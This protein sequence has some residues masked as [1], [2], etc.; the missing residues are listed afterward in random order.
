MDFSNQYR[1]QKDLSDLFAGL[2][3]DEPS[4]PFSKHSW[5]E[6]NT[7]SFV[8]SDSIAVFDCNIASHFV[9]GSHTIFIGRVY[10]V[11]KRE[12]DPLIYAQR[13]YAKPLW[14]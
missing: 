8:L 9:E 2:V 11:Y 4:D 7:G 14:I 3:N 6:S 1:N 12:G 10:D 5:V 13:A